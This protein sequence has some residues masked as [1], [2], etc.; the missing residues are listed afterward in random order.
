MSETGAAPATVP[1]KA[2]DDPCAL[3]AAGHKPVWQRETR[4]HVHRQYGP[5]GK[6]SIAVCKGRK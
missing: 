2:E 5:G 3:C 6:F 4:E 1:A